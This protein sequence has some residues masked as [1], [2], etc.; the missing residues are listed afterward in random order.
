MNNSSSPWADSKTLF[1]SIIPCFLLM[2]LNVFQLY[3]KKKKKKGKGRDSNRINFNA[4]CQ[5]EG[6]GKLCLPFTDIYIS[7][8]TTELEFCAKIKGPPCGWKHLLTPLGLCPVLWFCPKFPFWSCLQ[9]WEVSDHLQF[10]HN[11][12]QNRETTEQNRKQS[13]YKKNFKARSN[14]INWRRLMHL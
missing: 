9:S 1:Y 3:A 6:T 7:R 13:S 8:I 5:Q 2:P 4:M 11:H 14:Q 12:F 10:V